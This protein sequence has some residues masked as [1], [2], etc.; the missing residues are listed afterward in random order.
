[1]SVPTAAAVAAILAHGDPAAPVACNR[2]H[3]PLDGS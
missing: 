3:T 2:A 1:M